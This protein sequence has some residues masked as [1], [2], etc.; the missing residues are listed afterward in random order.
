MLRAAL[1]LVS[2][3]V[4]L[5]LLLGYK[6]A[7]GH[8]GGRP[9]ALAPP[10]HGSGGSATPAHK[11]PRTPHSATHHTTP[12][13]HKTTP[14][15]QTHAS[16]APPTHAPAPARQTLTG[17]TAQTPYGPVQ[18]QA[19]MQNGRLVD[20]TALQTP[21]AAQQS[22]AIASYAVPVLRK[23]AL[24]AGNAH[25]NVVSGAT[26]TSDGYAQSLQSA[27]DQAGG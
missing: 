21:S 15:T 26:Y 1:A 24:A 5:V 2:T 19:T 7:P 17:S 16:S 14:P 6:T 10:T 23:E 22:Q 11:S 13:A 18:V 12:P 9:A 27:L 4:G 25:I 3:V 8:S 20:V